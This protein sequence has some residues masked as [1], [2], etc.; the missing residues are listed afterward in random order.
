MSQ[1]D[2]SVKHWRNFPNSNPKP[3]LLHIN[4]CTKFGKNPLTPW[5]LLKLL[6]GNKNMGVSRADIFVKIWRNLPISIPIQVST[7][8]MHISSLVKIHWC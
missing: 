8:S 3:D 2:N 6:S 4:A 1:A 5:L 7:I